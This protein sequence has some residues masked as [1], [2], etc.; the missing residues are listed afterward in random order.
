MAAPPAYSEFAAPAEFDVSAVD[1]ETTR[2]RHWLA[3]NPGAMQY[4]FDAFRDWADARRNGLSALDRP[5]LDDIVHQGRSEAKNNMFLDWLRADASRNRARLTIAWI[6]QN[7]PMG[8][9]NEPIDVPKREP[10]RP[11]SPEPV[12]HALGD[13]RLTRGWFNNFFDIDSTRAHRMATDLYSFGP[14]IELD[15]VKAMGSL[16][17]K[18]DAMTRWIFSSDE[19]KLRALQWVNMQ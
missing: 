13:P 15:D 11:T 18:R 10:P 14:D 16:R 17:A 3:V 4:L 5:A 8:L 1:N 7:Y 19:R 12:K 6:Q 2:I 9:P